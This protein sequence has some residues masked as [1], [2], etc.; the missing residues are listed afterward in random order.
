[1]YSAGIQRLSKQKKIFMFSKRAKLIDEAETCLFGDE[2][3]DEA[4]QG[5]AAPQHQNLADPES[6]GQLVQSN[7]LCQC[8]QTF[9]GKSAQFCEK[10]PNFVKNRPKVEPY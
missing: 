8:D 10:S 4:A 2:E 1:M 9:C 3:R 6:S 5:V 7:V